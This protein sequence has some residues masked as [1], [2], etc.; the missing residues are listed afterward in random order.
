MYSS[1]IVSPKGKSE[2]E[3]TFQITDEC[4]PNVYTGQRHFG[5][6][7][8]ELEKYN[9]WFAASEVSATS[10]NITLNKIISDYKVVFSAEQGTLK[11]FQAD[12]PIDH[13]VILNYFHA[14]PVLYSLKEKIEHK[15][16]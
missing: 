7:T 6:T 1:E 15:L 9:N 11:D 13:K 2:I 10:D 4:L 8:V 5:K 14:R 12:I 16:E 3:T